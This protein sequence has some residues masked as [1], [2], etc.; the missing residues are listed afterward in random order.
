M[1]RY[2]GVKCAESGINISLE[3]L[4]WLE[5]GSI[6]SYDSQDALFFDGPDELQL[7]LPA[8]Y[9]RQDADI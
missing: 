1:A 8:H 7:Y 5:C 4:P 2:F 3:S 6:H 9:Y